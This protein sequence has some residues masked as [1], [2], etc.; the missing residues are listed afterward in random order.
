MYEG[1]KRITH[2][3]NVNGRDCSLDSFSEKH[4]FIVDIF[5][6]LWIDLKF[7]LFVFNAENIRHTSNNSNVIILYAFHYVSIIKKYNLI[8]SVDIHKCLLNCGPSAT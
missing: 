1:L 8:I 5:L 6:L 7:K 4:N 3:S 2:K